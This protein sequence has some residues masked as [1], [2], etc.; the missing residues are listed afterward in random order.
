MAPDR[1]GFSSSRRALVA[2]S[3]RVM[4]SSVGSGVFA[5]ALSACSQGHVAPVGPIDC[6]A[7]DA[8]YNFLIMETYDEVPPHYGWFGYGDNTPGA[9]WAGEALNTPPVIPIENGGPCSATLPS[10][11]SG[12]A[13]F[14][15]AQ[16]YQDYGNAWG[17]YDI[18]T[19]YNPGPM[20]PQSEQPDGSECLTSDGGVAVCPVFEGAGYDGI[21]FWARSYDPTG[22]PTT[23]GFT[24]SLNDKETSAGIDQACTPFDAGAIGGVYLP[25]TG[26][27]TGPAGGGGATAVPP[28]GACGNAF[29]RPLLTTN[30]WQLYTLPFASFYQSALPDRDPKG[31]FDSSALTQI[32][33][34]APKEAHSALWIDSLGFYKAKQP[35][36]GSGTTP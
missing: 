1:T 22:G 4:A 17:T 21:S 23:L 19:Y 15:N 2:R 12:S 33:I 13:M 3:A 24:I 25:P 18:G 10:G 9:S 30:Q 34:A 11:A 6:A 20:G 35:E 36:G 8:P 32:L 31:V 26:G 29:A 5:L 7:A 28:P 27:I 14:L 16:G